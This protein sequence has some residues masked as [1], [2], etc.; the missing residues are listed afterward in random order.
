[1]GP[2]LPDWLASIG[3]SQYTGLFQSNEVDFETLRVLTPGDLEELGLPFGPRKRLLHALGELE[4]GHAAQPAAPA[5][6]APAAATIGV[7]GERRQLTVLFCDMVGFTEL[8]SRVDP[9]VLQTVIG[10]YE[11]ACAACISRF[12]GYVFQRLGDGIVA[13]FGFPLA[14]E[15]EAD[16]AIRAGL[17]II[18]AMAGLVV[19]EMAR[20]RVRIGIATG[21]VVVSSAEKGAVGETMNLA[22]RLQA[23]AEPNTIAVSE[24]VRRVAGGAFVYADLGEQTFKGIAKPT[25]AYRV[26]G[27]SAAASRFEAATAEALTP[28]V[29][30]DDELAVLVERWGRARDGQGQIVRLWGEAGIGKSRIVDALLSRLAAEGAATIRFQCSPYHVNSAFQP[31]I[32]VVDRALAESRE[33]SAAARLDALETMA[34]ACGR[35]VGDVAFV[36]DMLS[37]PYQERYGALPMSPRRVKDETIRTLV[38]VAAAAARIRPTALLFEDAHWADPTTLDVLDRLIAHLADIPLMVVV[39]HRLEFQPRWKENGHAAA[40]GLS[41]LSR[42]E[43]EQIVSRLTGGRPLPGDVLDQIVA[44]TDGVPLFVEELTKAILESGDLTDEGDRFE[45]TRT[46]ADMAVPATLRDSLAARLDRVKGVKDVAQI[47]AA[48]G[49]EFSYELIAAVA[50]MA[51]AALD[52]GLAR[53]V[54][55]GLAHQQGSP[56]QATYAFKHALVQ[57][58]AYDSLLKSR[59]SELHV[60]I[61]RELETRFPALMDTAPETLAHHYTAAGLTEVAV[62]CWARAGELGVKRFALQEASAHLRR[63]LALIDG[64]PPGPDRDR[65]ELLLRTLL[66]PAIVA[67]RGWAQSEVGRVLEPAWSL[68]S[69]L[70]HRPAYTPVLHALWVHYLCRDQLA[71]SLEW[72]EKLLAAGDEA[73]DDG[74]KIVGH[75]AASASYFWLGDLARAR[76]HGDRVQSLYDA[77]RHWHIASLTNTD[78]LTGEAIYRAQYLWML[79]YPDQ[80]V[81]ASDARDEHARRRKHPFDMAFALTLGAQAFDLRSEPDELLRRTE[82]AERIGREHGVPLLSEVMAEISRGIAWLRAGRAEESVTQLRNAVSRLMATGHRV[83]VWYLRALE[84]EAMARSGDL[85]AALALIDDSIEQNRRGEQRAHLAE[86]LRLRGWVLV[87]MGR[88]AEAEPSLR[89]AIDL[90]RGQHARS[91]ELRA[92][93]TLAGLLADRGD[94]TGARELLAPIYGWFTEG[95]DT[96]DLREARALL[97]RLEG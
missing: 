93:T 90:A 85:A 24:R 69:S 1:V 39:T 47:G 62:R 56:P 45:F 48:I 41:R 53:L 58:A 52:E 7:A 61:A 10:R 89:D 54:A 86:M 9:E 3:L 67:H 32:A 68:A 25:R 34:A 16:R 81:A 15:G 43:S 33:Q 55:S 88:P 36:A 18:E 49:R 76:R 92:S 2:S 12:D 94:R 20:L 84:G 21:V 35:P 71:T 65:T 38:D 83:W 74:L 40:I 91:W 17:A 50:P 13:F 26:T 27:A 73:G 75:R 22:S 79:G 82:E 63:G 37:I 87:E 19:P 70:A 11:D 64:L 60:A 5:S 28:L 4:S 31:I 95:F 42:A 44:K 14:H 72:A 23:I 78:P 80:A 46:A 6:V 30:R 29:G 57:D 66:G 96:K 97:D 8:A 59:R 51:R 77:E